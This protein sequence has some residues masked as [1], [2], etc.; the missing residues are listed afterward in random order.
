M[1]NHNS[2]NVV[3]NVHH[4]YHLPQLPL[5]TLIRCMNLVLMLGLF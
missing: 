5:S 2:L 4:H 3:I 1:D